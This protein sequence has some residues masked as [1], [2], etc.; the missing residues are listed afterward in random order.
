MQ[1]LNIDDLAEVKRQIVFNGVKHDVIETS[2]QQFINALKSAEE[3]EEASSTGDKVKLSKQMEMSVDTIID[4]IPTI[5]REEL[6][7]KPVEVLHVI[8]K[9]LRGEL[10]PEVG[11]K[12]KGKTAAAKGDQKKG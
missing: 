4:S 10:D 5:P 8:L 12:A 7:K 2:V 9:F 3:L 11:T 6:M 1:I